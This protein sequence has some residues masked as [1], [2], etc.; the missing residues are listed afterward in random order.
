MN[1]P[2]PR[3][4]IADAPLAER[5]ARLPRKTR[6]ALLAGF[7]DEA[8]KL[9]LYDGNFWARPSQLPPA[10]PWLCWLVLAGRG[11]GK[12]RTGAEWIRRNVEGPT[13]LSA[14]PSGARRIALIAQTFA[15]A[16]DVMLEGESGL[17]PSSPRA[18]RPSYEPSRRRV[19]WPSGAAAYLYSSEEP[20]QLRGPQH[21]LAWADELA[22]WRNAEAAWANLMLG[23]RLGGRP[24]VLATTTPRPSA[25][26]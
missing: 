10:G 23:L 6:E 3:R 12:T 22:K 19:K 8:L 20:D 18:F 25:F 11:F 17:M 7:D 9:L 26:L 5:L 4:T 2:S 21:H 14:P 15:D 16:R 24:R 1:L 13:P